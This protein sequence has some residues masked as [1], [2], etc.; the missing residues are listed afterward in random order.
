MSFPK[1]QCKYCP[2]EYYYHK[3][4][5]HIM[6]DH[7]EV[8]LLDEDHRSSLIDSYINKE[9]YSKIVVKRN[10]DRLW[11][12]FGC[13]SI[14]NKE[15]FKDK[16]LIKHPSCKEKHLQ[17]GSQHFETPDPLSEAKKLLNQAMILLTSIKSI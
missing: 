2:N 9:P 4:L 1:Y 16:H 13:M 11:C 12:C 5:V 3:I 8:F 6:K 17:F 10:G 7:K 14:F 15:Y